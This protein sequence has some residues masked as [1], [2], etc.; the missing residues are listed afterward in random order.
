MAII[1]KPSEFKAVVAAQLLDFSS[2]T[3]RK[4]SEE[5]EKCSQD[6][7]KELRRT[8]PRRKGKGGGAYARGWT[9]Q[10]ETDSGRWITTCVVHNKKHYRLTHLLENG[11]E[12]RDG[13]RTRAFPHIKPAEERVVAE[14]VRRV[15]EAIEQ[16]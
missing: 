1:C 4:I 15:K 14:Y 7:V 10:K 9:N 3:L 13:G 2:E 11:H 6:C 5:T 8:S 16:G 12:T